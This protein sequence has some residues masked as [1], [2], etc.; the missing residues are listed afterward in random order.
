MT[1]CR[2]ILS[3]VLVLL[4]PSQALWTRNGKDASKV[5]GTRLRAEVVRAARA[6]QNLTTNVQRAKSDDAAVA[7]TSRKTSSADAGPATS[8]TRLLGSLAAV[9]GGEYAQ[10]SKYEARHSGDDGWSLVELG[11]ASEATTADE[12]IARG[13]QRTADLLLLTARSSSEIR[14]SHV[15]GM[16][17]AVMMVLGLVA[18]V[19]IYCEDEDDVGESKPKQYSKIKNALR[20]WKDSRRFSGQPPSDDSEKS[21]EPGDEKKSKQRIHTEELSDEG[22]ARD[23]S[24]D[25]VAASELMEGTASIVRI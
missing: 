10:D 21:S 3:C 11:S 6:D 5:Q 8:G 13:T 19:V 4:V 2:G 20:A 22:T 23:A 14:F 24:G 16:V 17:F 1:H 18:A 12:R 7:G 25:D 9:Y 15:V